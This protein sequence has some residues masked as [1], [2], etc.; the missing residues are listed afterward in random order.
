METALLVSSA[1]ACTVATDVIRQ[2]SQMEEFQVG[3]G[4]TQEVLTHCEELIALRGQEKTKLLELLSLLE[5][6]V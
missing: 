2:V 1:S 6:K 5:K 4:R 3:T